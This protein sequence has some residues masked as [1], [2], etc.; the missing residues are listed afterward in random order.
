MLFFSQWS[1]VDIISNNRIQIKFWEI[2]KCSTGLYLNLLKTR[3]SQTIALLKTSTRVSIHCGNLMISEP[4]SG[5]D[6]V[7]DVKVLQDVRYT[8]YVCFNSRV[9]LRKL[10]HF[11]SDN[12]SNPR[13]PKEVKKSS[14]G[15]FISLERFFQKRFYY[16]FGAK[17]FLEVTPNSLVFRFQHTLF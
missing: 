9:G 5:S 3:L 7:V 15:F 2:R 10:L 1:A 16:E 4:I 6:N 17:F 8:G 13:I 11:D 12:I 14:D